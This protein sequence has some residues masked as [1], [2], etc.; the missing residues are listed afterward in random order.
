MGAHRLRASN[1]WVGDG[2][3]EG[4]GFY[5]DRYQ[6]VVDAETGSPSRGFLAPYV[7]LRLSLVA[8]PQAIAQEKLWAQ[9][10][11]WQPNY[12]LGLVL[13][14]RERRWKKNCLATKHRVYL[15]SRLSWFS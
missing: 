14:G 5:V 9:W 1:A 6:D 10:K 13:N 8:L 4:V 12:L 7:S 11:K 3:L 15:R 2:P